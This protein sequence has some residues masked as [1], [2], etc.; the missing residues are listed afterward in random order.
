[1]K[2]EATEGGRLTRTV[3][4]VTIVLASAL[5]V[6]G[7]ILFVVQGGSVQPLQANTLAGLVNR[8]MHAIA[9]M[10]PSGFIEAGLLVLLVAPFLRLIAGVLQSAH[11]RDWRF[12]VVGLV[13]AGLLLTGI[14]LGTGG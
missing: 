5:F 11:G 8:A 2:A 9:G 7:L 14:V 6:L 12:V 1:M 3:I 13:V 10:Q 4:M